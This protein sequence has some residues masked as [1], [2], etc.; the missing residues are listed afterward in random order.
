MEMV[1]VILMT[2][3]I[4][5]LLYL[6]DTLNDMRKSLINIDGNG[7]KT[8][9]LLQYRTQSVNIVGSDIVLEV[10]IADVPVDERGYYVPSISEET[11]EEPAD[12]ID[13]QVLTEGEI[14]RIQREA[15][16]DARIKKMKD[17][18]ASRTPD[19]PRK[20]SE[21]LQLHP[22]VHNLPHTII[23]DFYDDL[24]DVEISQ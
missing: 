7:I 17:E 15:D 3:L 14:A 20:G 9:N 22:H 1:V 12:I 23:A 18:L 21:A 16:F 6:A 11:P 24:P 19:A 5:T 13:E 4:I 8:N 2:V 10:E